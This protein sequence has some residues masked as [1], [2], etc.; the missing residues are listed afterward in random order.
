M[1][2]L[3]LMKA[4]I[5]SLSFLLLSLTCRAV[6]QPAGDYRT[7]YILKYKDTAIAEMQRS[8]IPASI[9]MAQACLES[10]FGTSTLAVD[11]N[12]HFGIKCH[13]Y[14]GRKMYVDDDRK[15]DCFRVYDRVE[16][17]FRDHSDFL[18]YRDRYAFLFDL[19]PTDYKGWSYGLKAAGYAT[20]PAY[21][22]RLISLIERY[23]LQQYDV[24]V[25]PAELPVTPVE[26]K[27]PEQVELR[28]SSPLY[29]ISLQREILKR[30]NVIYVV[31]NGYESF[32]S[33]ARE[34][35][36]FTWELLRFND[37]KRN[38]MLQDG[39]I[40]YI[41]AKKKQ[42]DKYL[43]KHVVEENETM[44]EISQQYAVKMKYLYKYNPDIPRGGE[45]EPG[46]IINLRKP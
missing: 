46:S 25:S 19:D 14:T 17:S 33:I 29:K 27:M 12:N 35:N 42:A 18:R 4:S 24:T 26:A 11:G 3:A 38:R 40:I 36:L 32:A 5:I 45:P 1:L 6:E 21:A 31:A 2:K 23:D 7:Q 43:D 41:E 39:E 22:D 9:T 44:H 16:D 15:N 10:G 30:N 20:D 8:G 28:E 34:F 13:D 37:E